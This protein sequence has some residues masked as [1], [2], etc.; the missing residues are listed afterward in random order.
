[1][2]IAT[3]CP[4]CHT[5]WHVDPGLRGK[6]MRCPNALCREV[7]V[8]ADEVPAPAA[9]AA[10]AAL[11]PP[12]PPAARL[13][14]GSVGE[15]VPVLSAEQAEPQPDAEEPPAA[16]PAPAAA[17]SEQVPLLPAE[18]ADGAEPAAPQE[19]FSWEAPPPVRGPS[20]P[21][22]GPAAAEPPSPAVAETAFTRLPEPRAGLPPASARD[23]VQELP[24]GPVVRDWG[25]W[26]PPP[27]RAAGATDAVEPSSKPGGPAPAPV[28]PAVRVRRRMRWVVAAVVVGLGGLVAGIFLASRITEGAKEDERYQQALAEYKAGN[29][30]DAAQ[31]LRQLEADYPASE[32]MPAYRFL[33]ALSETL[34]PLRGIQAEPGE[35]RRNLDQVRDLGQHYRGEPLLEEHQADLWRGLSNFADQLATLA[36]Q[37]HDP[38]FLKLAREVL[39]ETRKYQPPAGVNGP[40][41]LAEVQ[42]AIA[43]AERDIARHNLRETVVARLER[44]LRQ[45]HGNVYRHAKTLLAGL[46]LDL[47]NDTKVQHLLGQLPEA[48]RSQVKF[49]RVFGP[50][51]QPP[52]EEADEPSLLVVTRLAGDAD[53]AA[54][55]ARVVLALVRGVLYA[56]DPAG[57]RLRW[58]RRV[59]VDATSLPLRLPATAVSPERFLVLSEDGKSLAAL[60]AASGRSLWRQALTAPCPGRPVVVGGHA[61]VPTAA[62]RLDEI[63]TTGGRLVGYY[64]LG[65]ALLGEAAHQPGTDLLY[66]PA[67][68]FSIYVLDLAK[69]SCPA[70]LYSEHPSGSLRGAP[71]VVSAPRAASAARAAQAGVPGYLVLCQAATLDSTRLRVYGLPVRE[72][73]QKPVS[74]GPPLPGWSWFSPAHDPEKLALATDAGRFAVYG[75]RQPGDRDPSLFRLASATTRATAAQPPE[76]DRALIAHADGKFFWVLAGGGLRKWQAGFF[77]GTGPRLVPR[78]QEP[79]KLGAPLHAAQARP[80]KDGAAVLFLATQPAGQPAALFSAVESRG[81]KVLWQHELGLLCDGAPLVVGDKVVARDEAGGLFLFEPGPKEAVGPGF[82]LGGRPLAAG[83]PASVQLLLRTPGGAVYSLAGSNPPTP[84]RPST[85]TLRRLA[86]DEKV[87]PEPRE[88]TLPAPIA[89]RPAA[90]PDCLVL[91]LANGF[92]VRQPLAGGPAASG[93]NWRARLADD[94]APG[95]VTWAGGADYL[96]TDGSGKLKRFAWPEGGSWE[97]KGAVDLDRRIT[98]PPVVLVRGEDGTGLRVCVADA[99]NVLTL[100]EGPDLKVAG[101]WQLGG[102]ITAGPFARGGRIG[103]VVDRRR[104]VLL[105]PGKK[106]LLWTYR[107]AADIVGEP[108][109]VGDVLVVASLDGH[110]A[111]VESATGTARGRGYTLTANVAPAAAPVPWRT[112]LLFAPLADGTVLLL[113]TARLGPM[114]GGKASR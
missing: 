21:P 7:F 109:V 42:L 46:N 93:P 94:D 73:N 100:L 20:A 45:P 25:S 63:E 16:A 106:D 31:H 58:A 102:K 43:T 96:V 41:K 103:C 67:D 97:E 44:F 113:P 86:V 2:N 87:T 84:G 18:G 72:P 30:V 13:V 92:L 32:R 88:I 105:D 75:F 34:D 60:E 3:V 55:G 59:G 47:Q 104:L 15:L 27:V 23:H 48:H 62:G 79:L 38:A 9:P 57:G 35:A 110:F 1:M 12:A 114:P 56:F 91:P 98:A 52:S 29:Y 24:G 37:Q 81:G 10:P 101:T 76:G 107:A 17:V 5:R 77:R 14:A 39:D 70:I 54:A 78:W 99:A 22:A 111:A 89:G 28:A 95:F 33:A 82:F 83:G 74:A 64:E 85:F 112:G 40:A 49:V 61:F 36:G 66:V 65:E 51:P 6:R 26:E 8:V 11:A 4:A 69:R 50:P 71:V 19:V 90:G 68:S 108:E 53:E 80:G